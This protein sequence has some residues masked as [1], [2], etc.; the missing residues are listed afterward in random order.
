MGDGAEEIGPHFFLFRFHQKP[1]PLGKHL[2]LALRI[3]GGCAGDKRNSQHAQ[4]GDRITGQREIK[5]HIWVGKK[6]VYTDDTD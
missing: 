2:N 1:F 6:K 4:E 3:G 5:R